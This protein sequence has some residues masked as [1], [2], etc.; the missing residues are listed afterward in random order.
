MRGLVIALL[1]I[2][3]LWLLLA[4]V[5]VLVGRRLAARQLFTLVP[6]MLRLARDLLRDPRVPRS[7]KILLGAAA[8]WVASP[9]D[10][11]PEFIPF[12]GP[13]DDVVVVVLVLRHVVRRA[14]ADVVREHWRGDPATIAAILRVSGAG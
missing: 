8:V 14:G 2:A 13:L 4:V 11:L 5:L 10:L 3:A 9:I 12:L 6:N 7:S 1:V